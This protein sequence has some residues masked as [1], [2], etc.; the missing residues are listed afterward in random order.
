MKCCRLWCLLV[1]SCA[2]PIGRAQDWISIGVKGGVP[3]TDPFA[4]RSVQQVIA[5]IP[6]LFGP[7]RTPSQTTRFLTGSRGFVLGP[8]LELRL[9][10]GLAVEAD[11]LYRPMEVQSQQTTFL[12][13]PQ[14]RVTLVNRVNAWEF[15]IL[16]K[17]RLPVPVVK[18]YIAA[19]P[20]FR[21]T[22]ASLAHHMSGRG[23]SAGIGVEARVGPL[24]LAPEVRYTHWG[25]DGGYSSPYYVTSRPNQVE[26][27][28]GLA[29]NPAASG[30]ASLPATGWKKFL[31]VGVKGGLPFTTAFL[32]DTY[33][34]VITTPYRC[35]DFSPTNAVCAPPDATV[36][37]RRASRNYLVG[38]SVELH[39][40]LRLSVEGDALYSPLSVADPNGQYFLPVINTT[41][42]IIKTYS[43]WSFPILAK[44]RF[45]APFAQPYL[46]AGPTFRTAESAIS[47][48]L[49]KAG[50]T[51]GVGVEAR[52][53]KFH[54]SPEVR[55]VHWGADTPG[56]YP[57]RRNQA[58]FLLG[59][60]Y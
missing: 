8:T 40:P 43:S 33:A 13:G 32:S 52:A 20:S 47:R 35:G 58:Q 31:T 14:P 7:P 27:L 12:L 22:G 57:S 23:V 2:V 18:P 19:G 42:S 26:F 55:F 30:A 1:V 41:A 11:A 44:Y 36:E 39:L 6:S 10:L 9:P 15:P 38:P 56:Y 37:T 5:I 34:R 45:H 25:A 50:V 53:W 51:A 46:E 48:Y 28:V 21:A 60:S 49:S 29:T 16:A 59:L 54:V 17:Y 3:L 4:D 24:L